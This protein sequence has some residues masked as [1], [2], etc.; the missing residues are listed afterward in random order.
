MLM[1]PLDSCGANT[2]RSCLDH[3]RHIR[4][5]PPCAVSQYRRSSSS[6][7]EVELRP[8]RWEELENG[9]EPPNYDVA[10]FS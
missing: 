5:S 9:G 7:E 3:N 6:R 1:K 4:H 2:F 8:G 10:A